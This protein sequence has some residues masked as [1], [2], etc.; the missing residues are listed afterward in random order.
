MWW[1]QCQAREWPL[2]ERIAWFSY[3]RCLTEINIQRQIF[4][5]FNWQKLSL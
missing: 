4:R 1:N 5:A 3:G 2:Q